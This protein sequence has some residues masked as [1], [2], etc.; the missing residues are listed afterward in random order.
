M[1]QWMPGANPANVSKSLITPSEGNQFRREKRNV[2][3]SARY[4]LK[5][6]AVFEAT[7]KIRKRN[8]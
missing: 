4:S 1:E 7:K 6:C 8:G 3:N 5:N 2:K